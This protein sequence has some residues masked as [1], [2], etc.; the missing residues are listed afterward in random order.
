VNSN[1]RGDRT[2][3]PSDARHESRWRE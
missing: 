2:N 3:L 1:D